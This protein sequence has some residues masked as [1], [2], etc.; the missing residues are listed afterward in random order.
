MPVQLNEDKNVPK[1]D[2][3]LDLAGWGYFDIN[4]P[5]LNSWGPEAVTLNYVPNDACTK[6]P[7]HWR[8][9]WI[10]DSS[11]CTIGDEAPKSA[12]FGDSGEWKWNHESKNHHTL[13]LFLLRCIIYQLGG[14]LNL[15]KSGKNGDELTNIQVGI[16][17]WLYSRC[18]RKDK[19]NVFT[20]VSEIADWVK[21]TVCAR[22]G[23]LC[24]QSK[25]G[26]MS[27]MEKKYPDTC[28]PVSTMAPSTPWPTDPPTITPQ[29]WTPYP[30]YSSTFNATW[31]TWMPTTAPVSKSGK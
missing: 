14:A 10:A 30:T 2:D 26:K 25:A 1:A 19:P 16:M 7:F 15:I 21:E 8:D 4:I 6:K 3:Q 9:E 27:K 20:R 17:S 31:P 11:L 13:H 22:K 24:K 5:R 12:C 18:Y 28:V 23:E 29:P